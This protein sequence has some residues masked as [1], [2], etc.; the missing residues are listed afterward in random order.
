M[1]P[2]SSGSNKLGIQKP[3]DVTETLPFHG[4]EN[5]YSAKILQTKSIPQA[6]SRPYELVFPFGLSPRSAKP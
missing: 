2:S 3:F 6:I 5:R 4:P 1:A